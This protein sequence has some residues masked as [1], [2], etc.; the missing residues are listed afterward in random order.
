[1]ECSGLVVPVVKITLDEI[2]PRMRSQEA[3][4][5]TTACLQERRAFAESAL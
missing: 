4:V 3:G 5:Y 1:M 2:V